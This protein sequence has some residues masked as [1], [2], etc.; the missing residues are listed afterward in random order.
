LLQL[1]F[2]RFLLPIVVWVTSDAKDRKSHIEEMSSQ[3]FLDKS[4][5][6]LA[7]EYP[8]KIRL[9][10]ASLSH[11]DVW[12]RTNDQSNSIGNLILHLAGNVRQ[13]IVTGIGGAPDS[14]DRAAE[15]AAT[16]GPD[17]TELL[18]LLESS[19]GDADKVIAS[20]GETDLAR[21]RTI[22][23]RETNVMAAIYHVVEHFSMHTGQIIMLAKSY[24]PESVKFYEDAGGKAVPLWGGSEGMR[25]Q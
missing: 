14:R 22:Q 7:T 4:R 23:G 10:T 3:I 5:Y 12:R 2:L 8:S 25:Q 21:S 24:S 18:D 17:I 13:W 11:D 6:Y 16:D 19:V 1:L 15:F 20:L 9:A